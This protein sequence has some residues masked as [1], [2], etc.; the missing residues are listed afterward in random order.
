MFE[1]QDTFAV[2]D[3]AMDSTHREFVVYVDALL[4][5]DDGNIPAALHACGEHL[6]AHFAAEDD[7]MRGSAYTE[8]RCHIDEHA[9]VLASLREVQDAVA[10][11]RPQVARAFA[12][13][14]MRWFPEHL[15][16]MDGALARW[17]ATRRWG[18]APIRIARRSAALLDTHS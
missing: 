2:G 12:H 9:K 10:A 18:G 11:G 8:A 15:E 17:L 7:S 6:R 1:W 5:A 4:R 16:V 14:L 13:A 3:A